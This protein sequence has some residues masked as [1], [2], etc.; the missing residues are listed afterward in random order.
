MAIA[1]PCNGGLAVLNGSSGVL[2]TKGT[3]YGNNEICSWRIEVNKKQVKTYQHCCELRFR[4][5]VHLKT[6]NLR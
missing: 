3:Y 1:G 6:L 2:S 4:F 5:R